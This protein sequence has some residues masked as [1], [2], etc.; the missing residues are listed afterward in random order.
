MF[1]RSLRLPTKAEAA[2]Q[3]ELT[4]ARCGP[5]TTEIQPAPKCFCAEAFH[6]QYLAQNPGGQGRG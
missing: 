1:G 3:S 6:Q 5:I 4:R 2:L